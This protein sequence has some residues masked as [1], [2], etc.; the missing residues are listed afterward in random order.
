MMYKK[1]WEKFYEDVSE[2]SIIYEGSVIDLIE[3]NVKNYR[4]YPALKFFGSTI[5]YHK[6]IRLVHKLAKSLKALGINKGDKVTICLPNIPQAVLLF[7]AINR[8][9][10]ICNMTHPLAAEEELFFFVNDSDSVAVFTLPQFYPKFASILDRTKVRNVVLTNP[11]EGLS[12][13]IKVLAK[14]KNKFGKKHDKPANSPFESNN[15]HLYNLL[16]WKEFVAL[17]SSFKGEYIY[18]S[19]KNDTAAIMYSGGTTGTTKGVM[20]SNLNLNAISIAGTQMAKAVKKGGTMLSVIPIF[21]GFGFC[22][23]IHAMLMSGANC[24]LIPSF[25]MQQ[26]IGFLKKYKPNYIAGVPSLYKALTMAKNIDDLD[27][28][29]LQIALSGGDT[30][31]PDLKED[32][33]E[34]LKV[35]KSNTTLREGYGATE[36]SAAGALMPDKI[37]KF[38]SI[39]IPLPGT[40]IRITKPNTLEEVAYG[41]IGE[42]CISGPNVMKGYANNDEETKKV[43]TPDEFGTIWLHTGDLASM[44]VD[45]FI[46]FR[47]RLKRMIISNGYNVYPSQL[48]AILNRHEA[49]SMSAVVG[50]KSAYKMEKIKAFIVLKPGIE[51]TGEIR[52]SIKDYCRRNIAKYAIPYKFI[53]RNDLPKTLF[54]KIAYR[55]LETEDNND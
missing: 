54:G 28:S 41:E 20:L 53:Y 36:C 17:S 18:R 13:I 4:F 5:S 48:E 42:I 24:V 46:Y 50:E 1:P 32:F 3:Q 38:G 2:S 47:Q 10:A 21:H 40:M 15:K 29:N 11:E 14:I 55:K 37:Y 45:G 22:I 16:S 33:D 34:F 19:D 39:G 23:C 31:P 25:Q 27:L 44:D 12:G 7:Y 6:F 26:F 9:G 51:N 52:E 43:L 49:I 35:H 8:I 30:L